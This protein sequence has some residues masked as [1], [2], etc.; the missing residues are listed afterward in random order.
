VILTS[1]LVFIV[2]CIAGLIW[3]AFSGMGTLLIFLGAAFIGYATG[4]QA[5]TLGILILLFILF[6]LG[7]LLEYFL[8]L[9]G[10]RALGSSRRAAWGALAGGILG[11]AA[12]IFTPIGIGIFPMT[13]LGIFLGGFLV[14]L[15]ARRGIKQA[16]KSGAGGIF[17]RFGA[18]A[19]KVLI[20]LVMVGIVVASLL[21]ASGM[22]PPFNL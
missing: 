4:F 17:G 9:I 15:A 22:V 5:I 20:T 7:E 19:T 11:L 16:L 18:I 3:S 21:G 13:V 8:V 14:E 6:L 12:G 10:A 2:F 1:Y